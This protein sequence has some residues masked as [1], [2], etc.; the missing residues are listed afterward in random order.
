MSPTYAFWLFL[1]TAIFMGGATTSRAYI[2]ND[3]ILW[4][5][6]SLSLYV[7]GNLIMLKLM[8]TGGLGLAISLSAIVQL[9]LVNLIAFSVFGERL[10]L[11]QMAGVGLGIVSMGL[12]MMPAGGKA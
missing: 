5:L 1:A 12:M 11:M 9:V 10:S 3:N 6:L 2:G 4:L 8:R 7:V